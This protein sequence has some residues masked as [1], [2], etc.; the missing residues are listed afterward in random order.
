[1]LYA[2]GITK[3]VL[4]FNLKSECDSKSLYFK[5][6]FLG[7]SIMIDDLKMYGKK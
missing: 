2:T 6:Q 4:Y 1:M 5:I 3:T 7:Q